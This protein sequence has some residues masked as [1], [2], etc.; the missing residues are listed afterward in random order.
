MTDIFVSY[1]SEDRERIKAL[2]VELER[3]GWSVWWD[4][5]MH[6]GPSFASVIQEQIEQALCVIVVW[7][8]ASIRS[9]WVQDEA[10]EGRD[11]ERACPGDAGR[12]PPSD[13]FPIHYRQR[14][15]V[16]GHETRVSFVL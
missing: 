4:R 7:S 11:R 14:S 16:T 2:V 3:Q 12:C 5:D 1:A 15:L 9:H 8:E 6:A 13:G 10:T